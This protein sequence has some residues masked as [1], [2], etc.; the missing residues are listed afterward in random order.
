M[1]LK[2]VLVYSEVSNIYALLQFWGE[3][4]SLKEEEKLFVSDENLFS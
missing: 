3:K 2:T 4:K 1:P